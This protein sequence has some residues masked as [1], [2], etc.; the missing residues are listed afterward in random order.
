LFSE[1]ICLPFNKQLISAYIPCQFLFVF[2]ITGMYYLS[3]FWIYRSKIRP[4]KSTGLLWVRRDSFEQLAALNVK[5][6]SQA[7]ARLRPDVV[8]GTQRG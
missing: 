7:V 2:P 3:P 4:S 6:T 8:T 1:I 5:Q